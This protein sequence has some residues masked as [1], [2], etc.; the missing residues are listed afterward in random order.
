MAISNITQSINNAFTPVKNFFLTCGNKIVSNPVT[1]TGSRVWV[2]VADK[3]KFV[4]NAIAPYVSHIVKFAKSPIGIATILLSGSAAAAA[5]SLSKSH[6]KL[7]AGFF[8]AAT[9]VMAVAS[10][11]FLCQS[12]TLPI[13]LIA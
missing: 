5:I 1:R 7:V 13:S 11:Y 9:V 12:G 10:F 6:N 8:L 2:F 4:W 3:V